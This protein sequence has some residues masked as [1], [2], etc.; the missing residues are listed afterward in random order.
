MSAEHR[1]WRVLLVCMGN[2]CRS[3]TAEGMLRQR[4]QAA[5]LSEQVFVDSCG[6]GAWHVG[7]PPDPRA[8]EAASRRG[9]DISGL[10]GR[11]LRGADFADFDEILVMDSDN[12]RAVLA[13]QR[14]C[15]GAAVSR[16]LRYAGQPEGDVPDPYFG[17]EAGFQLV[18]D[19]LEAAVE[20]LVAS[21]SHRLADSHA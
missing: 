17:G 21:L 1:A 8:I 18:L 19:H 2:I 14:S 5:G 4:L 13:L 11:Q 10:R 16:F 12:L 6:T 9:I 3:P 15:S 20:G 7:E